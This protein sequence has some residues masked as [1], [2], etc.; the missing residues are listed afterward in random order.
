MN[1]QEDTTMLNNTQAYIYNNNGIIE[2]VTLQMFDGQNFIIVGGLTVAPDCLALSVSA[3][4]L[5]IGDIV[6]V[7]TANGYGTR[8]VRAI[9]EDGRYGLYAHS[10]YFQE[11]GSHV[12]FYTL[13]EANVVGFVATVVLAEMGLLNTAA[14]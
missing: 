10:N 8:T 1:K 3:D 5:V 6:V 14:A 11:A 13:E 7:K 4:K 9:A 12:F 2:E